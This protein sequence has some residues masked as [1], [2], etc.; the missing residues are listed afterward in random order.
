MSQV[1][2]GRSWRLR[3]WAALLIYFVFGRT[4]RPTGA[5]YQTESQ[6]GEQVDRQVIEGR[7]D[8]L[9]GKHELFAQARLADAARE[10]ADA[11]A[12]VLEISGARQQQ[13]MKANMTTNMQERKSFQGLLEQQSAELA[14]ASQIKASRWK[15]EIALRE[16]VGALR[17]EGGLKTEPSA[18]RFRV[19]GAAGGSAAQAEI[20]KAGISDSDRDT[21]VAFLRAGR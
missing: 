17:I 20:R 12:R 2:A 9:R 8:E 10:V 6:Q 4:K 13:E 3:R 7:K 18:E 15:A 14:R 11:S 19:A 1:C 5:E 16:A 21:I